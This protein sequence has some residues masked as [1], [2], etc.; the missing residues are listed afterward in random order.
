[1]QRL[2]KLVLVCILTI[3]MTGCGTT[4]EPEVFQQGNRMA[5]YGPVMETD[6]AY[7]Y[8]ANE[9]KYEL[10]YF[11]KASGKSIFLCNKPEC[12]HDGNEFCAATAGGRY[13]MYSA[14]Y[15]DGI[16]IAAFE[17]E[18]NR[19]D[20]KLFKVS[21]DG[22][23]ME[24]ISTYGYDPGNDG[25]IAIGVDEKKYMAV[26]KRKAMIPYTVK[27]EDGTN[28]YGT[29]IVD[30]DSGKT[31]YLEEYNSRTSLGQ[32]KYIPY[33]NYLYY[34]VYDLNEQDSTL[35]RYHFSKKTN[36]EMGVPKDFIDYCIVDG[37]I[38][39]TQADKEGFVHL[40]SLNP[41]SMENKDLTGALTKED[42][43]PLLEKR[44]GVL[45]FDDN[46]LI[47]YSKHEE[48]DISYEYYVFTK[49]GVFLTSF[50][51][52][53]NMQE[54]SKMAVLNGY[55]YF[56]DYYGM[57]RCPMQDILEGNAKWESLFVTATK[58]EE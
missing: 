19:L 49:D 26:Y 46:Y 9:M 23:K 53:D 3:V 36:E 55:V 38:V 45:F 54:E 39:Y 1:M 20:K 43:M 50:S 31:E 10:H 22:T 15:E 11:D 29:A 6:S 14:I 16:Y 35:Y 12:S 8:N 51:Q 33:D 41:D 5:F 17:S 42:G 21:L 57:V 44:E 2:K 34:Y 4:E 47:T 27:Q 37:F 52:P 28:N 7:Y 58:E 18:E 13:V 32:L 48:S 24:T 40:Y 25:G 30:I 56:R